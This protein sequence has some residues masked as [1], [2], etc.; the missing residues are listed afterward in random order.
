MASV[1]DRVKKKLEKKEDVVKVELVG[2]KIEDIQSSQ[3]ESEKSPSG[4]GMTQVQEKIAKI[5]KEANTELPE[6][7]SDVFEIDGLANTT[8]IKLVKVFVK[9][10]KKIYGNKS[11]PVKN[12]KVTVED[13]YL[14]VC[15]INNTLENLN[16]KV[17]NVDLEKNRLI[18]TSQVLNDLI[19][20]NTKR[21]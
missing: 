7:L 14:E 12:T 15:A 6:T 4:A 9:E 17:F 16:T 10:A 13:A 1:A 2:K 8:T 21:A 5:L 19:N 11:F 3:K 18:A 20:K